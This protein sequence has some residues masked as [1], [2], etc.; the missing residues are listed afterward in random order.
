MPKM[1]T[2]TPGPWK[3]ANVIHNSTGSWRRILNPA[4]VCVALVRHIGDGHL[5]SAAGDMYDALDG[6][7]SALHEILHKDM[8]DEE[9]WGS[10]KVWAQDAL[11]ALTKATKKAEGES[12]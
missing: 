12:E 1:G 8:S 7:G 6:A 4:G 2:H 5:V 9:D 3:R 11:D 10:W